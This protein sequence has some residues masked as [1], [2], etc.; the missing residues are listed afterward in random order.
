[1]ADAQTIYELRQA[2]KTRGCPV[3]TLLQRSVA[4]YVE[5]IFDESMLDPRA[6]KRMV[7]SLGFCYEHTWQIVELKLSDALGQAILYQ[8]LV[9]AVLA[10][11]DDHGAGTGQRL[12]GALSLGEDRPGRGSRAECPA[13]RAEGSTLELILVSLAA[14]LREQDFVQEFQQS[15][16]L[17]LPHLQR[18]ALALDRARIAVVLDLQ[19]VRLNGLQAELAEFIR[20]NDYRFQDEAIGAEGDSYQRAAE[21]M[22]GKRRPENRKELNYESSKKKF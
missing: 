3:C 18:L 13:C 17:C 8:D 21:M 7:D 12:A 16:G 15:E 9:R 20:K 6:R 2:C 1:M 22:R 14:A 19:R 10:I 5:G 4:R 11:I